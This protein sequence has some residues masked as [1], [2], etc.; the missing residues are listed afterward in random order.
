M[1]ALVDTHCHLNHHDLASDVAGVLLRAREADV[2]RVICAGFDMESSLLAASQARKYPTVYATVGVHPH[3]A[4]MLRPRDEEE[5]ERLCRE[6]K[7]VAVGETGLDYHYDLSPR[8]IQKRAY[9]FHIRLAHKV[10]LPLVIHSREA[11]SDILEILADEGM[12]ESGAVLHCFSGDMDMAC[13]ALEMGCHLG[14]A[15][16]ITFR[17]ADDFRSTVEGLPLDSLLIETDAPYLA[18]H[19]HRGK[20][21]EPAYVRLV[22]ER[23]ADVKGI[24]LN[25]VAEST[26]ANALTLFALGSGS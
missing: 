5:L 18:P 20:R 13:R 23:L 22:A 4:S 21:N 1:P 6:E 12:P 24:S 8:D 2:G 11:G 10:G 25:E 17:S 14:I 3:D 15:G 9:R 26:T 19:P 16:T 7:V